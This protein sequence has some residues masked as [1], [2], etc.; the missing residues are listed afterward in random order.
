VV[1]PTVAVVVGLEVHVAVVVMFLVVPSLYVPVA[2]SWSVAPATTLALA[3][4]TAIELKVAWGGGV[5]E[6]EPEEEPPQ[7]AMS[8]V[9]ANTSPAETACPTL[10]RCPIPARRNDLGKENCIQYSL[11]DDGQS[12]RL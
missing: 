7:A 2:V 5:P 11:D 6:E 12:A 8:S 10:A 4:V 9:N 3:A 1:L